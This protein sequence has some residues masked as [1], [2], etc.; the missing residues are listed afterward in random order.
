MG[1]RVALHASLVQMLVQV[2]GRCFSKRPIL[3][4]S[5]HKLLAKLVESPIQVSRRFVE[6]ARATVFR[7][8]VRIPDPRSGSRQCR[9]A[10]RD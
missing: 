4:L 7:K 6:V 5:V 1:A 10:R 3:P 9:A 2:L 8:G